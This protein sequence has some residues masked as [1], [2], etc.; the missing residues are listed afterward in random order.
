MV[1]ASVHKVEDL[2]SDFD[3]ISVNRLLPADP[4]VVGQVCA[5]GLTVAAWVSMWEAL[6][7]FLIQWRPYRRDIRLYRRIAGAEVSFRQCPA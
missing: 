2:Y 3:R 4:G 7:T 5:E 1:D 6:A